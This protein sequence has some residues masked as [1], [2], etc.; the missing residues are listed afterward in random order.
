MKMW[1]YLKILIE[2]DFFLLG[3]NNF[4]WIA[5]CQRVKILSDQDSLVSITCYLEIRI[6]SAGGARVGTPF[7]CYHMCFLSDLAVAFFSPPALQ[8]GLGN[9][10]LWEDGRS[11]DSLRSGSEIWE[12][13]LNPD[14]G[15][16]RRSQTSIMVFRTLHVDFGYVVMKLFMKGRRTYFVVVQQLRAAPSAFQV[17][18]ILSDFTQLK[19][20]F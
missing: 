9:C 3:I 7:G 16:V 10:I 8:R 12:R 19:G 20:F 11:G 15:H 17:D 1:L 18:E 2:V 13:L 5:G 14:S 4:C 6:P